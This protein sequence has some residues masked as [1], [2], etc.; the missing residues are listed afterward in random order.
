MITWLYERSSL[1]HLFIYCTFAYCFSSDYIVIC[2]FK[3]TCSFSFLYVVYIFFFVF[4][5]PRLRKSMTEKC[6][7]VL[8][9]Y[10]Y[11]CC[12]C[13]FLKETANCLLVTCLFL[14]RYM[15]TSSKELKYVKLSVRNATFNESILRCQIQIIF[16]RN[17][18]IHYYH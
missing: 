3:L 4:V 15:W 1:N 11:Q 9:I 8:V 18:W 5:V 6:E 2:Q 12:F 14:G 17:F 10:F 13:A 16:I 7:R